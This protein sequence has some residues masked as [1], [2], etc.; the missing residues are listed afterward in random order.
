MTMSSTTD[1]V[2]VLTGMYAAEA[3]YLAAGGPGEAS[4]D[5][6]A[7][8][9]APDVELHQADALPYGGTWRGHHGMTRFFLAM[10][11]AWETFHMVEQEFLATGETAVVL[12][13]V[14]ARA[15]ATGRELSFPILQTITVKGGRITEVRPFYWDTQAI[16]D[17]CAAS[18][19][20]D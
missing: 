5:L 9:F 14:R 7:P 4:F 1:S 20:T 12:T 3:Q 11:R 17:A 15:R 18:A 2:T 8:F 6:L 10:G 13:Q 19:P 16:A